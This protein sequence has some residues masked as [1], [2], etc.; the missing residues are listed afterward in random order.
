[1]DIIKRNFENRYTE[2]LILGSTQQPFIDLVDEI[3]GITKDE[4][5]FD[6]PTK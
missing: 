2:G 4:D 5:Y 1:M 3:Y 6:N